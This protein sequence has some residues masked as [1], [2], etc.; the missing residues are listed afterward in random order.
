MGAPSH[1][2][3]MAPRRPGPTRT[4]PP[5][6]PG[7][8]PSHPR[9]RVY[10]LFGL[11]GFLYMLLAFVALRVVWNLGEG[12]EAWD[13][14]VA[15]LSHP[16]YVAFHALGL[17]GV[18]FVLVRFFRLFPKSQPAKIGPAKPPPGSVIHAMLYVNWAGLT[19]AFAVVL[20]G[21]LF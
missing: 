8:W 7:S 20:A 14:T 16:I 17:A 5:R 13:A 2:E 9:M 11:T 15:S 18:A 12:P 6:K 1:P 10:T 3:A 4:A 19:V 21:G